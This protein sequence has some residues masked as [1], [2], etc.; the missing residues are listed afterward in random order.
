MLMNENFQ[1]FDEQLAQALRAWDCLMKLHPNSQ[2]DVNYKKQ[3]LALQLISIM[4]CKRK[5]LRAALKINYTAQ[6]IVSELD[7]NEQRSLDYLMAVNTLTSYL[8]LLV[9]KPAEA[10]E[11]IKITERIA[12]R[13][14]E[15]TQ[16]KQGS[17]KHL[18]TIGEDPDTND[19][20]EDGFD[21]DNSLGEKKS[22]IT[23]TLLSNYILSINLM[24]SIATKYASDD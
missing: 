2:F 7:E 8:L 4:H 21:S 13:L 15:S 12:M 14:L 11:F 10:L 18:P 6:T 17:M 5:R 16:Q 23:G 1:L 20:F 9:K 3:I 24:Q 22:Q 19:Y